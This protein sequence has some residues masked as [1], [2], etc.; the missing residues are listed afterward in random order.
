[1]YDSRKPTTVRAERILNL[2][3]SRVASALALKPDSR[4]HKRVL[5]TIEGV[6]LFLTSVLA[7]ANYWKWSV[8][9]ASWYVPVL[10]SFTVVAVVVVARER[11]AVIYMALGGWVVY[12]L[13][14]VILDREPRALLIIVVV[15]L[16]GLIVET[17]TRAESR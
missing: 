9:L 7:V 11:K 15:F 3:G 10:W 13:K 6:L 2:I 8:G 1:M 14:G 12:S 17:A 16:I 4:T 5:Q